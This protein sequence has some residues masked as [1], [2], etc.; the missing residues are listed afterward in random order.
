MQFS[1]LLQMYCDSYLLISISLLLGNQR[2]CLLTFMLVLCC[3]RCC[4]PLTLSMP[5]C[6]RDTCC[7]LLTLSQLFS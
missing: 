7:Y 4:F 5:L 3:D 2:C 6:N 1:L